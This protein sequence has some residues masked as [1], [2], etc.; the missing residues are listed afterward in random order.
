MANVKVSDMTGH[1]ANL[2][3]RKGGRTGRDCRQRPHLSVG[4]VDAQS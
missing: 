1:Q 2:R 3:R 4:G